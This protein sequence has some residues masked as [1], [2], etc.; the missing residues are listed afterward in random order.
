MGLVPGKQG[1]CRVDER[2]IFWV[3]KVS[4]M[5]VLGK[6]EGYYVSMGLVGEVLSLCWFLVNTKARKNNGRCLT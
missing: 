1:L 5:L 6:W 2:G 4:S 3:G